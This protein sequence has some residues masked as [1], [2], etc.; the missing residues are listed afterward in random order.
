MLHHRRYLLYYGADLSFLCWLRYWAGRST[1]WVPCSMLST[2]GPGQHLIERV[3]FSPSSS[4]CCPVLILNNHCRKPTGPMRCSLSE[5]C[6]SYWSW[7]HHS[8]GQSLRNAAAPLS[9]VPPC[10]RILSPSSSWWRCSSSNCFLCF[11]PNARLS[12]RTL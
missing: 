5:C 2:H 6:P 8:C 11:S 7:A 4:N 1:R 3:D 10:F 9:D 12:D